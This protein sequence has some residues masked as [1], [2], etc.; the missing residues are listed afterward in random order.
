MGKR[1]S[2]IRI[3]I[4]GLVWAAVPLLAGWLL[5]RYAGEVTEVMGKLFD[6]EEDVVSGIAGAVYQ[7]KTAE[8]LLPWWAAVSFG[9]GWGCL[10]RVAGE[11]RGWQ[12]FLRV[13]GILLLLP[14]MIGYLWM[15]RIN[16]I[17]LGALLESFLPMLAEVL[18]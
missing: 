4:R 16:G 5:L 13:L 6:L 10:C 15:T 1:Q 17:R 7:L 9:L 3:L 12:V 8:L 14:L 2:W 18:R 11:R